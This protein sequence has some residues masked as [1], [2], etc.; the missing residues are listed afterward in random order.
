[1]T[2]GEEPAHGQVRRTYPRARV[3]Q[4]AASFQGLAVSEART[5]EEDTIEPDDEPKTPSPS[6]EG[7]SGP[8][9]ETDRRGDR[10]D[11]DQGT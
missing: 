3:R 9:P 7:Y 11:E 10:S 4:R 5:P 2:V 1:M 8:D 6:D